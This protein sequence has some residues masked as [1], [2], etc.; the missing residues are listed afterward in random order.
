MSIYL[1]LASLQPFPVLPQAGPSQFISLAG[2]ARVSPFQAFH[3]R[4][5][6]TGPG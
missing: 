5:I 2:L 6:G 4:Q 1:L 3:P